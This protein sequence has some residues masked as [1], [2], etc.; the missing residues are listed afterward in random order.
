MEKIQRKE[1][2]EVIRHELRGLRFCGR[3]GPAMRADAIRPYGDAR[4]AGLQQKERG[5]QN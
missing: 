3:L 5:C 2:D 1:A 4:G